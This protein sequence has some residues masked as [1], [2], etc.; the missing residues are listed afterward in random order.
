MAEKR[1]VITGMGV[2]GPVGNNSYDFWDGIRHEKNGIGQITHFDTAGHKACMGAEVKDFV[3]PDKRAAK[4]L[5]L[6]SQYAIVAVREAMADSGLKAGENVDPYRF[7]VIG[8]TGIGGIMT[9]E[10]ETKKAIERG[11]SRVSPLM[12]TMTIPNMIA[13]NISIETG[14]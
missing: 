10:A 7:G 4:R 6:S 3:F 5:D 8:G 1:V 14:A 11:V 13:G 2:V 12:V 9:L